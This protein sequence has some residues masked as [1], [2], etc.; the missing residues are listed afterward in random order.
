MWLTVGVP[1]WGQSITIQNFPSEVCQNAPPTVTIASTG[2]FGPSNVYTVELSDASGDFSSPIQIGSIIDNSNTPPSITLSFSSRVPY[3]NNYQIRVT[4]S[5]PSD[6]SSVSGPVTIYS[7]NPGVHS[8]SEVTV[9]DGYDPPELTFTTS[10]SGGQGVYTYQWYENGVPVGNN[11][12]Y[13]PGP[14]SAGPDGTDY[15]YYC[16]V[17][18]ECNQSLP[19]ASK[20]IHVVNDAI[21]SIEGAGTY[22]QNSSVTLTGV[23]A[24]AT[25]TIT[26]QWEYYDA[27]EEWSPIAGANTSSFN[28]ST[29]VPG[30][31]VYRVYFEIDSAV[32]NDP[33]SSPV[34]VIIDSTSV[35]GTISG[36][37]TVCAETNS[38]LLT[39]SGHTGSVIR[40]QYSTDS[41]ST[42]ND[43]DNTSDTYTATDLTDTTQFRAVVQSGVCPEA[44]SSA[45][46]ITV[47]PAPVP[48][49][50]TGGTNVCTGT[51]STRLTLSGYTGS[52]IRWQY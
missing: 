9:C 42:W 30:E 20:T 15:V 27:S 41:G 7:L 12:S 10:P 25:G 2:V 1:M 5:D 33:Y 4:S 52:V 16:L 32:C 39:L 14:L 46:T 8:T 50:V 24:A 28:P 23:S 47:D 13:D 37:A 11:D 49:D 34:S 17:T 3:G 21:V 51:N 35:G 19:T 29:A 43:I 45:A 6:T 44:F 40:W 38:T 22:C 36:E 48:G 26:Y 18:D 31:T